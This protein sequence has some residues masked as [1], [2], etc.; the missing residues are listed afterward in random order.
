MKFYHVYGVKPCLLTVRKYLNSHR[1][2]TREALLWAI[3]RL[4]V[5]HLWHIPRGELTLTY[6]PSGQVILFKGMDDP[7]SL[8]SIT[9]ANGHLCWLWIEEIYELHDKED[10]EK[11]D[12]SF[13]GEVPAPLFKQCTG[14]MN[15]WSDLTWIKGQFFDKKDNDV[16]T[17]T[18]T[19]LQNEFLDDA[20]YRLYEKMKLTNPRR[21]QIV[22]LG[23]WGVSEGLIY[24]DHVENPEKNYV[25]IVDH[26]LQFISVGLDYGSGTP[27]GKLGKTVLSAVAFTEDWKKVYCIKESYYDGFFLPEKIVEWVLKFI[28]DLKSEYKLD[29]ILHCEWASSA[30]LNNALTLA[31]IEKDIEGVEVRNAYKSTILSRIDLTQILLGENRLLLTP[32]V[33]GLKAAFSTALWDS[34][35]KAKLKG[36]PIRLDNGT[37]DICILDA[38]EYAIIRYEKYLLAAGK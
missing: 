4:G 11:L 24:A 2:S 30:A 15:P 22:G 35:P 28:L 37:T 16:F 13:R 7:D 12:M 10:F 23:N 8:T 31:V 20:D 19:Y 26:E 14:I 21:Y 9:I 34:T 6:L 33:P 32:A 29:I 1:N 25:E 5:N 36:V 18:T 3:N 38:F 27:E 17:A